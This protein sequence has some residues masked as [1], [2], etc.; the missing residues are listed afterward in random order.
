MLF[1]YGSQFDYIIFLSIQTDGLFDVSLSPD[2]SDQNC[3]QR[4]PLLLQEGSVMENIKIKDH[5]KEQEEMAVCQ[6]WDHLRD[7]RINIFL[8]KNEIPV[9]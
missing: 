5:Q 8:Q 4:D 6:S 7:V 1:K 2:H 3:Q 9:N